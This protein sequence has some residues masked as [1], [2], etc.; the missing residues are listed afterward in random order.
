MESR[1]RNQLKTRGNGDNMK[2]KVKQNML[3]LKKVRKI[4]CMFAN[5]IKNLSF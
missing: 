2:Q 3:Q 1:R 5:S 4:P